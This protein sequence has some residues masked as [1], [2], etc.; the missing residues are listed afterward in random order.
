VVLARAYELQKKPAEALAQL[1]A[2]VKL[3]PEQ[4]SLYR[5]RAR[6]HAGR[7]ELEKALAELQE[8]IARAP[9]DGPALAATAEDWKERGLL[10]ARLDRWED[11]L[12]AYRAALKL[13]P[14]APVTQRLCG[15][16]LIRLGRYKEAVAV[17]DAYLEGAS[18]NVDYYVRVLR[19][20]VADAY[21]NRGLARSKVTHPAAALE[22]YT[23]AL[24]IAPDAQTYAA[25]GWVYVVTDAAQLALRDFERAARLDP[26]SGDARAGLG[27]SRVMLGRHREAT[28]DAEAAVKLGPRTSRLL[29]N[30]AR[31]YAQAAGLAEADR[32][33]RLLRAQYEE[34]AVELLGEALALVPAAERARFW[35]TTVRVDRALDS[36]RRV[37]GFTRLAGAH[38]GV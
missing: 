12:A 29:Y 4:P 25:R 7:G 33:G 8:A 22:D 11:A 18:R 24:E 30:A 19:E 9:R 16:T 21:R 26:A 2:A 34:R 10:L 38:G 13:R 20:P 23:R 28:D 3:R 6:L 36:L 1:D 27:F 15:E 17:L 37:P 14:T 32:G 5:A 35:Q 31:T